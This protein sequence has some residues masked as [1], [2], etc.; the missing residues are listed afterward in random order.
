MDYR[1]PDF[2]EPDIMR[3]VEDRGTEKT[4]VTSRKM[5]VNSAGQWQAQIEQ[6]QFGPKSIIYEGLN[7]IAHI[8][9]VVV[10]IAVGAL[11]ILDTEYRGYHFTE[12]GG[13]GFADAQ[14]FQDA[15][16][17]GSSVQKGLNNFGTGH[18][19]ECMVRV[20]EGDQIYKVIKAD[21]SLLKGVS[22]S[23]D[24][25]PDLPQEKDISSHFIRDNMTPDS[26]ERK[27]LAIWGPQS[28][29]VSDSELINNI[30]NIIPDPTCGESDLD[31]IARRYGRC[32]SKIIYNGSEIVN[33]GFFDESSAKSH[34]Y[35]PDKT[36]FDTMTIKYYE[37]KGKFAIECNPDRE[38]HKKQGTFYVKSGTGKFKMQKNCGA[39]N[40]D[41][42][43]EIT[44]QIMEHKVGEDNKGTKMFPSVPYNVHCEM[45]EP[46]K[47]GVIFCEQKWN[48]DWSREGSDPIH[49]LLKGTG[50]WVDKM[51]NKTRSLVKEELM[52]LITTMVNGYYLTGSTKDSP[53]FHDIKEAKM[54]IPP[55]TR[56]QE[57]ESLKAWQSEQDYFD[58]RK[59]EGHFRCM[60]CLGLLTDKKTPG[61]TNSCAMGHI[62]SA[63]SFK[64]EGCPDDVS[65]RNIIPICEHCNSNMGTSHMTDY[66]EKKF[67]KKSDNYKQYRLYCMEKGKQWTST[68][69]NDVGEIDLIYT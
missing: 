68:S 58:Q 69:I 25:T 48:S 30:E 67:G 34:P 8:S 21:T 16:T 40:G 54:S 23:S 29:T 27:T 24:G 13:Y 61:K 56:S 6:N 15:G 10:N 14:T 12:K 60:C 17:W 45:N 46:G 9:S 55:E 18:K 5:R 19:C 39:C 22:W 52:D 41:P 33:D 32:R 7:N 47:E 26:G 3:P 62:K 64:E 38:F 63:N 53:A 50:D 36:M 31:E 1:I 37:T 20:R 43:A 11:C 42:I 66:M 28:N 35:L 51:A 49:L 57:I 59:E 4:S 44:M 65:G 2:V